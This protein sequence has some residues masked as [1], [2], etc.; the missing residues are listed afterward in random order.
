MSCLVWSFSAYGLEMCS[1]SNLRPQDSRFYQTLHM[2][3][4]LNALPAPSL[5]CIHLPLFFRIILKCLLH[6]SL[7]CHNNL[8]CFFGNPVVASFSL[9][10]SCLTSKPSNLF[11]GNPFF[12]HHCQVC[13]G[14]K[15]NAALFRDS[16]HSLFFFFSFFFCFS[17]KPSSFFIFSSFSNVLSLFSTGDPPPSLQ[18]PSLSLLCHLPPPPFSL[19]LLLSH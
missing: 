11:D 8:F 16:H 5:T 15:K 6:I 13:V 14:E 1:K 7:T 19:C 18:P 12:P 9:L 3:Q 10:C 2:S 17:P 4:Q